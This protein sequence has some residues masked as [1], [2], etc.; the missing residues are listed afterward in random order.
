MVN[1]RV[2]RAPESRD[3]DVSAPRRMPSALQRVLRALVG[4]VV[5][6]GTVQFFAAGYTYGYGE[7]TVLSIKGLSWA[8]PGAFENDWFN[9]RAPQPH[10]TFDVIT[11]FGERLG[12]LPFVY[13][14]Y[15]LAS[16]FVFAFATVLLADRWLP[17]WA[18]PAELA[19]MV[20]AVIGPNY[21][22]GT[23]LII[24]REAV[25]MKRPGKCDCSFS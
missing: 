18:R 8:I 9:D 24:H 22:L 25:P 1:V 6:F 14:L 3:T 15:W 17:R 4:T 5:L 13:F 20:L 7:Q 19:V 11:W 10:V 2:E 21:V 16:L 12:A 23:F